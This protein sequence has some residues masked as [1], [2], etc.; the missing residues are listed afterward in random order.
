MLVQNAVD[1][2]VAQHFRVGY[3]LN[4]QKTPKRSLLHNIA[5]TYSLQVWDAD[6]NNTSESML[7]ESADTFS[8]HWWDTIQAA[9]ILMGA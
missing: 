8:V 7:H 2:K 9:I 1:H 3:E 5:R 6:G 4:I